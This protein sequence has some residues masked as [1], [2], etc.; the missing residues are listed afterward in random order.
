MSFQSGKKVMR[1]SGLAQ[2]IEDLTTTTLLPF[3]HKTCE[4]YNNGQY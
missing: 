4:D 3:K 1:H 2:E